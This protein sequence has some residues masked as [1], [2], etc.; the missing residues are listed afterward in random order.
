MHRITLA[1]PLLF[2]DFTDCV[3]GDVNLFKITLQN[4]GDVWVYVQ[5][6]CSNGYQEYFLEPQ[7]NS[8]VLGALNI[9]DDVVE[10]VCVFTVNTV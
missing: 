1:Y 5:L 4:I 9:N 8:T 10:K 3:I 7:S 2:T 6:E